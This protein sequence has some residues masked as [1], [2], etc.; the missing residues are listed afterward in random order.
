MT[1]IADYVLSLPALLLILFAIGCLVMGRMYP[2]EWRW[3]NGTTAIVGILFS[4]AGLVKVQL[5]QAQLEVSGIR[6]Q[7]GFQHTMVV[8]ELAVYFYYLILVGALLAILIALRRPA[9]GQAQSAE[10]PSDSAPSGG[11]YAILLCGVVGLMAMVSG[12]HLGFMFA[13]VALSEAAGCTMVRVLAREDPARSAWR[14]F[15]IWRVF[16]VAILGAGFVLLWKSAGAAGLHEIRQ[17]ATR[18]ASGQL[19]AH[20]EFRI[21]LALTAIGIILRLAAMPFHQWNHAGR[22][23]EP[24][25][26][27]AQNCVTGILSAIYP[28]AAWAMALHV[29]LWG[30]YPLRDIYGPW[31]IWA[32]V[33]LLGVGTLAILLQSDLRRLVAY[34]ALP[35]AGYMLAAMAA[36]AQGDAFSTALTAGLRAILVYLPAMIFMNIGAL[37]AVAIQRQQGIGGEI[38]DLRGLGFRAPLQAELLLIA[39]LSIIGI[40]PL[41]GF[42]GKYYAYM[43]VAGSGHHRLAIF[44]VVCAVLGVW[45][46][47]RMAKKLFSRVPYEQS[48]PAMEASGAWAALILGVGATIVTGVHPQFLIHLANWAAHLR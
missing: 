9:R 47:I 5:T 45:C 32:A 33:A 31:L 41:A 46:V 3:L 12:F 42:Y 16:S 39:F 17:A 26:V 25:N 24:V 10:A 19:P 34:A 36:V 18:F 40:P 23:G 38:G 7:V 15:L 20:R 48:R 2:P 13:G 27:G 14:R 4:I 22:D 35:A 6:L 30:M 28:A 44:G 11:F 29:F 43:S 37:A 1:N 8:D 21:G